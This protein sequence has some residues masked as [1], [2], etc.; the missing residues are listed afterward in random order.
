MQR[1]P[2]SR[3]NSPSEAAE[4]RSTPRLSDHPPLSVEGIPG[5]VHDISREGLSMVT[6]SQL[7]T[8][9]A[10]TLTLRDHLGHT[11]CD[12]VGEVVWQRGER[13]GIRFP[14]LTPTQDEWLQQR[15]LEW[16]AALDGP[17][18]DPSE[19]PLNDLLDEHLKH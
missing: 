18:E 2:S 17:L 6:P 7:E 13:V 15:F 14:D 9:V 10:R 4:R 3:P 12:I 11:T 19:E 8:G 1:R 5:M 16:L